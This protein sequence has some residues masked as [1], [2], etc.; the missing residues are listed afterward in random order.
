MGVWRWI[1]D[2][3]A[4]QGDQQEVPIHLERGADGEYGFRLGVRAGFGGQETARIP[5][6]CRPNPADHPILKEVHSCEVA[7][8]HLEAANLYALRRKV[9]SL[10]E[11]IAPGHALPLC[12]FRVPEMDYELPVYEDGERVVAPV[13][14]GPKLKADDLAG[15]RQVVCR[16]MMSAGYVSDPEQVKVGVLRPRDLSRV[17]PAAVFRSHADPELWIPSVE[18]TSPEGPVVGLL[19]QAARL[20]GPERRRAGAGPARGTAAP[21]APDVI[22]MLRFLRTE[23]SRSGGVDDPTTLYASEV[24]PEIWSSAERHTTDTGSR[25]VAYLSDE[26]GSALELPVRQ[27]GFGEVVT[28]L[29]EHGISVLLAPDANALAACLGRYLEAH[30][31]LRFAS[32]IEV[33]DVAAPR[34]ERLDADSIWTSGDGFA[35]AP[36]EPEEVHT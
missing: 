15:V 14:A 22:E 1:R 24:R 11:A 27:T 12:Y 26:Q 28:A 33:H 9:A 7:G 25:L 4:E 29:E 6:A 30:D 21:A 20:R 16:Y 2:V 31:F 5:I 3:I 23:L 13:L 18:G 10:L 36:A 19:G 8:Q 32:E 35:A 34:A 17:A